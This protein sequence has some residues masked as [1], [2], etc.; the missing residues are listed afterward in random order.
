MIERTMVNVKQLI[1]YA[2]LFN[3]NLTYYEFIDKRKIT[4]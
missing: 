4:K 2:L 3:D 1:P